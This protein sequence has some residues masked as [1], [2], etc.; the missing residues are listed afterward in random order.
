M[1][2]TY[3]W[4]ESDIKIPICEQNKVKLTADNLGLRCIFMLCTTGMVKKGV[5]FAPRQFL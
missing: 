2:L 3:A 1:G 5:D 4:S